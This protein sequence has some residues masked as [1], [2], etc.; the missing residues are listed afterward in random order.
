MDNIL[1][2][3]LI[4]ASKAGVTTMGEIIIKSSDSLS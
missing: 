1:S 3:A 2:L 4:P